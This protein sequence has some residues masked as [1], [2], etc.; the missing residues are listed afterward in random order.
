MYMFCVRV[1]YRHFDGRSFGCRQKSVALVT[2]RPKHRNLRS[3]TRML[4]KTGKFFHLVSFCE[5][6]RGF[7][8][9]RKIVPLKQITLS[10]VEISRFFTRCSFPK[11]IYKTCAN[12]LVLDLRLL[13][14]QICNRPER[15]KRMNGRNKGRDRCTKE[16]P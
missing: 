10:K 1:G 13:W 9:L 12:I 15:D 4:K 11:N 6:K 14:A 7:V 8:D 2:K 5:V 3:R 16:G